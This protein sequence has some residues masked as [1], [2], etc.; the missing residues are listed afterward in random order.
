M[1]GKPGSTHRCAVRKEG[2]RGKRR[3]RSRH[4]CG[5]RWALARALATPQSQ[6]IPAA[7]TIHE[8]GHALYEQGRNLEYDGL[9]CNEALSM[10]VHESQ[11]LLWERMV[12]LSLPF[13]R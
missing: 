6:T 3:R 5:G 13:A 12:G 1:G 4:C 7:G 10:G 11:S 8:T 2:H 9:P